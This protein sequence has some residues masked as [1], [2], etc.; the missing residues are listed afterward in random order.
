MDR[1]DKTWWYRRHLSLYRKPL[2]DRIPDFPKE[3]AKTIHRCLQ[4]SP[5]DRFRSFEALA[6][7]LKK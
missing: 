3:L 5:G 6:D 7:H 2:T 4:K 1:A